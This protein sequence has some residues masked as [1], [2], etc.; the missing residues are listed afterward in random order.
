MG[1]LPKGNA[2]RRSS[3]YL[4]KTDSVDS[5]DGRGALL[6]ISCCSSG[7]SS[8][9]ICSSC[10]MS[11][12]DSVSSSRDSGR[13][14]HAV[15]VWLFG[16]LSFPAGHTLYVEGICA[17]QECISIPWCK[18]TVTAPVV[19]IAWQWP[20]TRGREPRVDEE[21]RSGERIVLDNGIHCDALVEAPASFS[22][23]AKLQVECLAKSHR[24]RRRALL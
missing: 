1:R 3:S 5:I 4:L 15:I 24:K 17:Q 23:N 21:V 11:S 2:A 9:T 16:S 20:T 12:L 14:G 10:R 13:G 18:A 19:H 7:C 6:T 8:Q 22:V